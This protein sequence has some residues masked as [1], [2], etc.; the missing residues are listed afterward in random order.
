MAE[1]VAAGGAR[2]PADLFAAT[3]GGGAGPREGRQSGFVDQTHFLRRMDAAAKAKPLVF[4]GRAPVKRCGLEIWRA[5]VLNGATQTEII[6]R[7]GFGQS[8]A[9]KSDFKAGLNAIADAV[10]AVIARAPKNLSDI[11]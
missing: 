6:N 1:A 4:G 8:N 7:A 9:R 11:S 5:V 2:G 10:A 3:G